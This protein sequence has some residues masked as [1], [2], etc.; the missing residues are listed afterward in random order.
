MSGSSFD[1][2]IVVTISNGAG[3]GTKIF[4]S[5]NSLSISLS[6]DSPSCVSLE[7]LSTESKRWF[8][9]PSVTLADS[10]RPFGPRA[11]PRGPR[12]NVFAPPL[13]NGRRRFGLNLYFD[14]EETDFGLKRY[15]G[16]DVE[17]VEVVL[18]VVVVVANVDV[19]AGVIVVVVVADVE[20]VDDCSMRTLSLSVDF[21]VFIVSSTDFSV[22]DMSFSTSISDSNFSSNFLTIFFS[23][24]A[25]VLMLTLSLC[26]SLTT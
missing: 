23:S 21:E 6:L 22:L 11:G 12:A 10:P 8:M 24:F 17:A 20:V 4:S 13:T 25:L 16:S 14:F 1:T 19:D 2:W 7:A 15:L 5:G 3:V 9:G 18:E 26:S